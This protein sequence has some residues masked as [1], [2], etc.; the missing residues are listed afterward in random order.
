[1]KPQ[2]EVYNVHKTFG[3]TRALIDVTMTVAEGEARALIGRNGAGKSTLVSLL[4]G[5]LSPTSGEIL[6]GGRSVQ[7]A[8]SV[9][10]VYQHSRLVPQMT[11]AENIVI[12]QY[13]RHGG[14]IAWGEVNRIAR[15]VLEPWNLAYLADKRVEDIAPVQ[16]KVVEICRALAEKPSVL[17]LDEPTA[18]LDRH[19]AEQLFEF[20]D[21]LKKEKV[22]LIYV[23]HHLDEIYRFCGSV[24]VLRD[25]RVVVTSPLS[26]L[27][28]H[29]L[30]AAMM[31]E[32][33][34]VI[35]TK[36][37]DAHDAKKST[38]V[39][40]SV[41]NLK[42]G[43]VVKD[44]SLEVR[45]GECVGIAG[46]DGSGKAEIGAAIAGLILP[47]GGSIAVG[48][49]SHKLGGVPAAIT[50][51]IGY[52]PENRNLQGM[53]LAL[54]VAENSTMTALRQLSRPV[55]PGLMNILL[56]STLRR[57]YGKLARQ[58]S[59]RASGPEQLISELSGGNQQKCVM[60]RALATKPS[61]L[62]LQNPTAGV[63]VAAKASIMR[64]LD[65]ILNQGASIVVISEDADDF[66]L[67]SRIVVV[68]HGR[69]GS[70]LG[71][72]WTDRELVA[73]MQE[74]PTPF[75]LNTPAQGQLH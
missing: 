55:V 25:S 24:T 7:D 50:A 14:R 37:I 75:Q 39:G 45:R 56:P 69:I 28:K 65:E 17:M 30:I 58:W 34:Q 64:S 54:S 32:T 62:I 21:K 43:N 33:E 11:V 52:V 71:S 59:I 10:C 3:P 60:A 20:I 2:I 35:A 48:G 49:K 53:V 70:E 1:M 31:G 44:F 42:V 13:P 46:L 57:E 66:A 12:S 47:D 73:A 9:S 61:V 19:D 26:E 8:S 18:G 67:A 4:T 22:T 72:Q 63:D 6:I 41:Q 36:R 51:G 29:E 16:K 23:S 74:A 38:P 40:L 27:P 15:A 68:N 5:M